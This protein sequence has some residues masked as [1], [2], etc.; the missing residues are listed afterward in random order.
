MWIRIRKEEADQG[1]KKI[2][3]NAPNSV[4]KNLDKML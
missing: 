3:E 2:A 1:N 4:E